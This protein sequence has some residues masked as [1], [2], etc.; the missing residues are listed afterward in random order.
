[1]VDGKRAGPYDPSELGEQAE[2]GT[3]N[4]DTLVWRGGMRKWRTA[5]ELDEING[6][7]DRVPPP[8]PDSQ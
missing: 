7:L 8:V 1:V 4:R 6:I 5:S 2:N 3:L